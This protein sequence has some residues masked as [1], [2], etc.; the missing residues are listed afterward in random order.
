M[1]DLVSPVGTS[2]AVICVIGGDNS[3]VAVA[4]LDHPRGLHKDSVLGV[5]IAGHGT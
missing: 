4:E 2:L 5:P 3:P 1:L